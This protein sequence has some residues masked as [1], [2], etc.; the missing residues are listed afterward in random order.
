KFIRS[1]F[2]DDKKAVIDFYNA[3]GYRDAQIVSDTVISSTRPNMLNVAM[4][5]EEGQRYYFRNINWTGNYVHGDSL[6][7]RVLG[8]EK[9]DVYDMDLVNKRLNFDPT[10]GTDISAL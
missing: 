6:L 8:I 4:E 1:D 7:S 9:G 5:I 2:E 3:K 10:G